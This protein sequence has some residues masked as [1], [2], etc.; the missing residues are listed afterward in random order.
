M[1]V[2]NTFPETDSDIGS[3]PVDCKIEGGSAHTVF[4]K[5]P[6]RPLPEAEVKVLYNYRCVS[7]NSGILLIISVDL[8]KDVV[9]RLPLTFLH[10]GVDRNEI[11]RHSVICTQGEMEAA[12][13]RR[14]QLK[15]E[16]CCS[17]LDSRLEIHIIGI[18]FRRDPCA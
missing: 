11:I 17:K 2:R 13:G 1:A 18:H 10:H 4:L 3:Q 14:I 9:V 7:G 8:I 5:H 15:H 6:E 12:A 16:L